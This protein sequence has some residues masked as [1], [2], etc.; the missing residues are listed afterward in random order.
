[1]MQW[2]PTARP[3]RDFKEHIRTFAA[4]FPHVIAIRG[5]GGYGVYMLGSQEP[6]EI[7]PGAIATVLA[8]PGV[9]ADISSAY[10]S[11]TTPSTAGP[12]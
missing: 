5:A 10:D 6:I 11:P 8:R 12:R 7:D 3:S 2:S 9:L 4:V 1:M